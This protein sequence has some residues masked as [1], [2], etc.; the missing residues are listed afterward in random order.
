MNKS[1]AVLEVLRVKLTED[2]ILQSEYSSI[3]YAVI[4]KFQWSLG[5]AVFGKQEASVTT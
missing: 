3:L 1:G 4:E 5:L 2:V